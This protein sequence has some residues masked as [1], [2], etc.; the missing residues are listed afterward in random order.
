MGG[1]NMKLYAPLR[2]GLMTVMEKPP[3][4]APALLQEVGYRSYTKL[5]TYK[6]KMKKIYI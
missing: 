3:E 2:P 4:I 1:V 5:Y 6:K